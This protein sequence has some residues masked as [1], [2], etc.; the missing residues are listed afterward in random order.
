MPL[1]PESSQQHVSCAVLPHQV[2]LSVFHCMVFGT[3]VQISSSFGQ[4]TIRVPNPWATDVPARKGQ[5]A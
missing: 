3:A 4:I 1:S 2:I 5:A